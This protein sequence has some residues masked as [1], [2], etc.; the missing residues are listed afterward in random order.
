MQENARTAPF[1]GTMLFLC[2]LRDGSLTHSKVGVALIYRL[3]K[4]VRKIKKSENVQDEMQTLNI[5]FFSRKSWDVHVMDSSCLVSV[6]RG[7]LK[8]ATTSW[9]TPF[10]LSRIHVKHIPTTCCIWSGVSV[11][12]SCHTLKYSLTATSRRSYTLWDLWI[13][14]H[15]SGRIIPV[16]KWFWSD[17]SSYIGPLRRNGNNLNEVLDKYV[18]FTIQDVFQWC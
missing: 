17:S 5:L 18:Q 9:G 4:W 16:S 13:D 8:V 6:T 10:S 2:A 11:L 3:E 1:V 15:V 7:F 14:T 12:L